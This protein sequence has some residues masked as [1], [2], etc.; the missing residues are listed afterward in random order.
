M[1]TLASLVPY[2]APPQQ[3][4]AKPAGIEEGDPP[5]PQPSN[6][7]ERALGPGE[8]LQALSSSI[9][10]RMSSTTKPA[11]RLAEPLRLAAAER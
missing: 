2:A 3:L 11:R 7:P 6:R 1:E 4:F 10:S 9:L 8:S 5:S